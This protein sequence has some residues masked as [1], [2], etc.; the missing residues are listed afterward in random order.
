[1]H[2]TVPPDWPPMVMFDGS[3]PN[4]A[5]LSRIHSQRADLVQQAV[6]AARSLLRRQLRQ[7]EIAENTEALLYGDKDNSLFRKGAAVGFRSYVWHVVRP[8]P[9][10]QTNTDD[11]PCCPARSRPR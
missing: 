8:P 7:G 10:N 2:L 6:V 11:R 5:M 3:P 4:A 9:W 1:M